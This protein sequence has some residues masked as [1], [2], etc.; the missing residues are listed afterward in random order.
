MA[1]LFVSYYSLKTFNCLITANS[2]LVWNNSELGHHSTINPRLT[3]P[4]AA[5]IAY[6]EPSEN[7]SL[8]VPLLELTEFFFMWRPPDILSG[9]RQIT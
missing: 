1:V 6:R 2:E 8:G 7:S 5:W 4:W 9:G 3:A